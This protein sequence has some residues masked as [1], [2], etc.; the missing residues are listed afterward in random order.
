MAER[1]STSKAR[2][3]RK[4]SAT[5][6]G[7]KSRVRRKPIHLKRRAAQLSLK[8]AIQAE[9][10]RLMRADAVLGSV[11]FAFL[12]SDPGEEGGIDY[13]D[14]VSVARDL[15]KQSIDALEGVGAGST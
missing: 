7:R 15:V 1:N 2:S 14:A 4:L 6:P 9:R 13:A 11:A 10:R 8:N 3:G 12:Y 5:S